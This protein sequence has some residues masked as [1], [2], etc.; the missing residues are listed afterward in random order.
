MSAGHDINALLNVLDT[1]GKLV[2]VGLPSAKLEINHF[3]ICA[4]RLTFGGS[5]IGSISETQ[6]R[7]QPGARKR[8]YNASATLHAARGLL[9]LFPTPVQ[10]SD[11]P[12]QI[13]RA[14]I[15]LMISK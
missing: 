1:D 2:L 7:Q 12:Q 9:P 5:I 15:A 11:L 6:V 13:G 3:A 4:K 10:V 14:C 8:R